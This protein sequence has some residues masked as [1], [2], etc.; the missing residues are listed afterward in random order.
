MAPLLEEL[1]ALLRAA[2]Y[3]GLQSLYAYACAEVAP[4]IAGKPPAALRQL[5]G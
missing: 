4:R 1:L 5:F 2:D 3:A